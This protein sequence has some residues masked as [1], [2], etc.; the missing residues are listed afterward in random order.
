MKKLYILFISIL[1]TASAFSQAYRPMLTNSSEWYYYFLGIGFDG[2]NEYS[3]TGDTTISS[4]PY[5][6]V[7]CKAVTF[8]PSNYGINYYLREDSINKKVYIFNGS[9]PE[10]L[11][12]YNLLPGDT[13]TTP[14][15]TQLIL[16]SIS[17][18]FSALLSGANPSFCLPLDSSNIDFFSP[19]IFHFN[20]NTHVWIEG[21][22]SLGDFIHLSIRFWCVELLTCHFDKNGSKDYYMNFHMNQMDGECFT[23]TTTSINSNNKVEALFKVYPNPNNGENISI[24]GKDLSSVKIYNIQGQ[25]IKTATIKNDEIEL[26]LINQSK[27]IYFIKAQFVTGEIAT[28]K[29][30]IN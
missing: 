2:T 24:I 11:Y 21:I 16:D 6:I 13:F 23:Y 19:K 3:I 28:Q 5:K 8:L 22:G 9:M 18:N 27:G 17:N 15:N 4:L 12:D 29:L 30:V 26:S 14:N 1:I 7:N 10:L 25:L 20:N